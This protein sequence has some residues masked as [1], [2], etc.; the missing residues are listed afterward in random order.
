MAIKHAFTSSKADGSDATIVRP[1]DWNAD[2]VGRGSMANMPDGTSGLVLTAQGAG[3]DPAYVAGGGGGS[4]I[5]D[6]DADTSWDVE[7]T[8]NEDK[9][10]GK[11]KGVEAFLLDDAGVLTLAKQSAARAELGTANQAISNATW[12]KIQFNNEIY[13][14]QSEYDPTTNY[15]F[16]AKKAGIYLLISGLAFYSFPVD[17]SAQIAITKNGGA[18]YSNRVTKS[19]ADYLYVQVAGTTLL[20]ANDYIEASCYQNSGATQNLNYGAN[21][22]LSVA[23]IA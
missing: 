10:H 17:G 19:A 23:K 22:Y 14:I 3:V 13:D 4:K 18:I 21:T 7:Q 8:A 5:Q 20:A 15:R 6:A 2:H 16:T 12:R 1:I 9:I 11:V